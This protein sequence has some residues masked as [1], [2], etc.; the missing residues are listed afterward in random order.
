MAG[1]NFLRIPRVNRQFAI[2]G[3]I[4]LAPERTVKPGLTAGTLELDDGITFC[5]CFLERYFRL[6]VIDAQITGLIHN[7]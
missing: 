6:C 4:A 5:R 1:E 3:V 2:A 7:E